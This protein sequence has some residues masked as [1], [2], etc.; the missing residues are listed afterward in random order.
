VSWLSRARIA[1]RSAIFRR[2]M[3]RDMETELRFHL[4]SYA[5]DLVRAGL[6]RDEAERLAQ[7]RNAVIDLCERG[8][9]PSRRPV[10]SAIKNPSMKWTQVLDRYIAQT[11]HEMEAESR[12]CS[13]K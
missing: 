13:G 3:E 2:T 11:L 5:D 4:S 7:V 9:N 12:T 1:L 10:T 6:P 8:I